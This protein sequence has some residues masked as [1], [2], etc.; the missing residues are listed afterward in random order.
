MHCN[1]KG[2][3]TID[4][5]TRKFCTNCVLEARKKSSVNSLMMVVVV[6]ALMMMMM[7]VMVMVCWT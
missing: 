5:N 4:I 6:L 3:N 1:T 7:I 2:G